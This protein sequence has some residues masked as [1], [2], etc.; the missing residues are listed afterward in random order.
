MCGHCPHRV[1]EE[2]E[3]IAQCVLC[4]AYQATKGHGRFGGGLKSCGDSLG[5]ATTPLN[6]LLKENRDFPPP[7]PPRFKKW[8]SIS[9]AKT[10]SRT[11][12]VGNK[13]GEGVVHGKSSERTWEKNVESSVQGKAMALDKKGNTLCL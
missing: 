7:L 6:K 4:N 10:C 8:E 9:V 1:R 13:E 5:I 3:S 11:R 12:E 2:N